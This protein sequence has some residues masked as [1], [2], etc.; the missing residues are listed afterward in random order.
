M[1]TYCV[2]VFETPY[3][4]ENVRAKNEQEAEAKVINREWAGDYDEI[5]NVEVMIQCD[6]GYDNDTDNKKCA[7]CG[8]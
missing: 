2:H 1:K 6:C 4:Y 7:E 8:K 3:K 5:S